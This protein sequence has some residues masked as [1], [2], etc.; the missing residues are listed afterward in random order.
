MPDN[1]YE[2]LELQKDCK[3][4]EIE[5]SYKKLALRYHPD[6]NPGD[7]ECASKFL[8]IQEAYDTLKDPNKRRNY[9]MQQNG[10]MSHFT[11]MQMHEFEDLNIKLQCNLTF[12]ESVL[13]TKKLISVY[14]KYP[15]SDC[16]GEGFHNLKNCTVCQGRGSVISAFGGM[17]RFE[18]MCQACFGRGKTGSD[19]CKTC[20]GDKYL[21]GEE[22]KIDVIIPGGVK[23]GIT[24][25]V[26]SSGHIGKNGNVG[27]I[28]V[29]CI[30]EEDKKYT[31]KNLDIFFNFEVDFSTMLFGGKIEI[32]TIE[33]DIIELEIPEKTQNL[34]N[35]RIKGKGMPNLTN[36][37][38]R[39]DL[40]AVVLTKIPTDRN[41]LPE[42]S[43]ILKHHSV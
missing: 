38:V 2:I 35:F 29:I 43:A 32:P 12:E 15:C 11:R 19:K 20:N 10:P 7:S 17:I 37:M 26:N 22:T 8:K 33:K 27:N 16:R 39:G 23:S 13:G 34:T 40:V 41:F 25:S 4:D 30:V 24:L 1:Y 5:K 36:N 42:F 14:K 6:R 3:Q 9:D 28:L 18:S 31:V 21:L